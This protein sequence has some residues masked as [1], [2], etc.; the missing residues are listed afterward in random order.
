MKNT[1]KKGNSR[2]RRHIKVRA[3]ISGTIERP[4]LCV[5]KSN[6]YLQVQIIDDTKGSTLVSGNTK[7]ST[8]KSAKKTDN[9]MWLGGEIAKRAKEA[10]ITKVVFDR[11]GFRYTGRVA[12]FADA[13]RAGGIEF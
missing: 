4:R 3:R 11:G 2:I 10:H 7:D 5:F 13:V 6:R 12:A 1:E 8:T 9:A